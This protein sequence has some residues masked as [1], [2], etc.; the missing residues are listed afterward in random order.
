M[1]KDNS[2]ILLFGGAALAFALLSGSSGKGPQAPSSAPSPGSAKT[3][4]DFIKKYYKYAIAS[5]S[6]TGVPWQ[7]TLAQAG[8]ESMW[9]KAAFGNNFF[10]IKAGSSWK[11][12]IQKLKTWECSKTS[13]ELIKMYAPHS[14]GSN[15]DDF[16]NRRS[17]I[18]CDC[19]TMGSNPN[20]NAANK[21]SYRV[22]GKF[23]SY[24]SPEE[25]FADHGKFLKNNARYSK[26]FNYKADP[27]KF[28]LEVA[29]AGYATA[30]NYGK[31]LVDTINNIQKVL[32]ISSGSSTW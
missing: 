19:E 32:N 7:L 11:G 1:A 4:T 26:A 10:G 3:P 25:G 5:Q 17:L 14:I 29:K 15:D 12:S 27:K 16:I 8:L 20:C 18:G 24:D 9:G 13:D 22:Y 31:I 2:N 21:P 30:P 23:R 6:L 28:A